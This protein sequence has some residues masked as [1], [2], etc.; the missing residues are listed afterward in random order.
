MPTLVRPARSEDADLV[1]ALNQ[2]VQAL[3]AA[4]LPALFKPPGPETFPPSAVHALLNAPRNIVMIAELDGA[5]VGYVYGE[6]VERPETSWR[7]AQRLLYVHQIGVN[8]DLRGQG[9]GT[10]LMEAMEAAARQCG[11]KMLALDVWSF[12]EA[13]QEFFARRAFAPYNERWWLHLR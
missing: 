9:I 11:A 1:S 10:A 5:G 6:F 4:A 12:N 3:H 13:A 2:D 7:F 8:V